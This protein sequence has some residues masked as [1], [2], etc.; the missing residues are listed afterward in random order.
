MGASRGMFGWT[1][2]IVT[3]SGFQRTIRERAE[4]EDDRDATVTDPVE[5]RQVRLLCRSRRSLRKTW[6]L[7]YFRRGTPAQS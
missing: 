2:G 3:L 5:P 1:P 4:K 6:Y 7:A